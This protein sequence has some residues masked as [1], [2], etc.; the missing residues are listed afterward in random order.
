M[1]SFQPEPKFRAALRWGL[2]ALALVAAAA[3]SPTALAQGGFSMPAITNHDATYQAAEKSRLD[4][5]AK[6]TPLT[7]AAMRAPAKGDWLMWRRTYDGQGFSPLTQIN[8]ANAGRLTVN[9][10]CARP[11][12]R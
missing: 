1:A 8:R 3:T 7:D 10:Y 6:L 11:G 2:T 12:R 4:T 5:L 9:P